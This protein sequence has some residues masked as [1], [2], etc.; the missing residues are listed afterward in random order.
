MFI[1][2]LIQPIKEE[3]KDS[4]TELKIKIKI[5]WLNLLQILVDLVKDLMPTVN[6]VKEL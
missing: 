6:S 5:Q 1:M 4:L 3:E 2:Y